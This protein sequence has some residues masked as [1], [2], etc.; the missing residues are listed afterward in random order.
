MRILIAEDEPLVLKLLQTWV[1]SWGYE[2]VT[3]TDGV[4]AELALSAADA[5]EVAILDWGMP[6]RT[7]V[8]ICRALRARGNDSPYVILITGKMERKDLL[9]AFEAG[10]DDFIA[11]PLEPQELQARVKAAARIVSLQE[12]LRERV[13]AA[14]V[15]L[16][17][18]E[19]HYRKLVEN[20]SDLV[21]STDHE[22]TLTYV[23]PAIKLY[24]LKAAD[25][26]GRSFFDFIAAEDRDHVVADFERLLR[27]GTA[28][29]T[30]F[31]IRDAGGCDHWVED[32]S[33]LLRDSAGAFV[34]ISG[35][36][37]NVTEREL[38][39]QALERLN[40]EL[41]RKVAERTTELEQAMGMAESASRAKSEFLANMSHE[42]RTP[43]HAV[44]GFAQALEDP[45]YG[46]LT[47]KQ[48]QYVRYIAESGQHLLDLIN[49]ILD[50]SKVEAGR[51]TLELGPVAIRQ[52]L[53]Q[54]LMMVQESCL[55]HQIGLQL[56]VDPRL[57]NRT[58]AADS[59]K[60]KQ[61]LFNLLSNSAKFTPDWGRITV[62]AMALPSAPADP[63]DPL[64]LEAR[65]PDGKVPECIEIRVEDTG[66]GIPPE[67]QEKVFEPFYQVQGG[68]AGKS[69]GTGLGLPLVKQ[70]VELHGGRMRLQ[71]EGEDRG[72]RVTVRI[73]TEAG[74]W[75]R[76]GERSR[77]GAAGDSW[78]G[79][80]TAEGVVAR[81]ISLCE[82][83]GGTVSICGLHLRQLRDSNAAHHQVQA[84]LRCYDILAVGEEGGKYAVLLDTDSSGA[85]TVCRRLRERLESQHEG[86]QLFVSIATYPQDGQTAEALLKKASQWRE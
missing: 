9:E 73:P 67:L 28:F 80:K 30:I 61:I 60:L 78:L 31:R 58:I 19:S 82:R 46:E 3:A 2:S 22:G 53:D 11:K 54:S 77:L 52:V 75:S 15:T 76:V 47:E 6:F 38:A 8:E 7:G 43:L 40:R 26:V 20:S 50:L 57:C 25:V 33:Q 41:D 12:R 85:E 14:E 13:K 51:M 32:R 18:A 23:S 72:C 84:A 34:G 71:S 29:P 42:L 59:R 70:L 64:A 24:G 86:A 1:R 44:I 56:T 39:R 62:T 36:L 17:A 68:V 10:V 81:A 65:L 55:R 74:A 21:F 45:H 69:P 63:A 49:D 27:L 83:R 66:I 37:R 35:F 48:R 16:H 4:Q 5:P 79:G